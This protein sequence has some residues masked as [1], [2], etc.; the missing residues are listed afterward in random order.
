MPAG[1]ASPDTFIFL[2]PRVPL[3][4]VYLHCRDIVE[5]DKGE[6]RAV[7]LPVIARPVDV[8]DDADAS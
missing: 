2:S 5:R 8:A 7:S 6:E 4:A 1:H 3:P